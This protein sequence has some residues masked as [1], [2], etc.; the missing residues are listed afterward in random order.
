MLP[1]HKPPGANPNWT[2]DTA[3]KSP[4]RPLSIRAAVKRKLRRASTRGEGLQIIDDVAERIVDEALGKSP[5]SN[6]VGAFNTIRDTVDGKPVQRSVTTAL[7]VS[8]STD[9][10]LGGSVRALIGSFGSIEPLSDAVD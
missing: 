7:V 2:P 4:G 3:P 1:G 5:F 9:E 6:V 10:Q 8:P